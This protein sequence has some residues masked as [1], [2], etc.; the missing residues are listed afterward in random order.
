M[1]LEL[2]V[3]DST[4]TRRSVSDS[5]A[6]LI[7]GAFRILAQAQAP[8]QFSSAATESKIWL[9]HNNRQTQQHFVSTKHGVTTWS[10]AKPTV[11]HSGEYVAVAVDEQG[12]E[13]RSASLWLVVRAAM[14]AESGP[15]RVLDALVPAIGPWPRFQ[16][17]AATG[18]LRL[19]ESC[20]DIVTAER[21]K[22]HRRH[23]VY[24][25]DRHAHHV[26]ALPLLHIDALLHDVIA[27]QRANNVAEERQAELGAHSKWSSKVSLE[28][29]L[30]HSCFPKK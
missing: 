26:H 20:I 10:F 7:H 16:F 29:S 15:E 18:V 22:D 24:V 28:N 13:V 12:E 5:G 11:L 19:Y 25:F 30:H 17:D 3:V 8:E 4:G 21:V 1:I 14:A 2:H 6:T 27:R 9:S 23:L